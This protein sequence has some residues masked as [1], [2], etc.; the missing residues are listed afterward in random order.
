MYIDVFRN[1]VLIGR[2][3]IRSWLA[4]GVLFCALLAMSPVGKAA[5]ATTAVATS[6][7]A[8]DFALRT[9]QNQNLRLSEFRGE[10]VLLNFWASWCGACRQAM[11]SLNDMYGKYRLAGLVMLSVNVEDDFRRATSMAKS[12]SIAFPVLLDERREVS[13]SLRIELM[14]TTLLIDRSGVIR[15]RYTGYNLNDEQKILAGLR[16]LLNE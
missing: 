12:L 2:A 15:Y 16:E 8:P 1:R 3:T 9:L 6:E 7:E 4:A 13:K 11:P 14:P 10:V 5:D